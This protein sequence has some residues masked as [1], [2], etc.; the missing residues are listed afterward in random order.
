M[1]TY[2]EKEVARAIAN[3][4]VQDSGIGCRDKVGG[5]KRVGQLLGIDEAEIERTTVEL[6]ERPSR[7]VP[8]RSDC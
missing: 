2:T 7:R 6:T 5:A 3:V 4:I 8:A 1:K